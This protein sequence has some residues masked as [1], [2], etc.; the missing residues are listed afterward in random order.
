MTTLATA[1]IDL[2]SLLQ[3]MFAP[4][5]REA[6]IL[7][8]AFRFN[9]EGNLKACKSLSQAWL[10]CAHGV[11]EG[12]IVTV[13][14]WVQPRELQ[15]DEFRIEWRPGD[16]WDEAYL[17]LTGPTVMQ[18]GVRENTNITDIRAVITTCHEPSNRLRKGLH[19]LGRKH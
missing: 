2:P 7:Q 10:A 13:T 11:T 3:L 9:Q 17:V 12:R 14:G 1:G 15:L 19:A 5:I 8:E 6:E 18:R 4:P 16:N